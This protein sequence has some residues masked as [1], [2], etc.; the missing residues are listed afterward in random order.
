MTRPESLKTGSVLS[1]MNSPQDRQ[2]KTLFIAFSRITKTTRGRR[3]SLSYKVL[4]SIVRI[5]E[6][7]APISKVAH[8]LQTFFF[9]TSQCTKILVC[10]GQRVQKGFRIMMSYFVKC[11]VLP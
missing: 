4:D 3:S 6:L 1:N 8:D 2:Q 5:Q 11:D 9:R 10:T 7:G